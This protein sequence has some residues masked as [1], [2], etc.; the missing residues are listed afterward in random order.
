[1]LSDNQTISDIFFSDPES[2]KFFNLFHIVVVIDSTYKTN[3]YRLHLLE[4]V[5]STYAEQMFYIGFA[6]LLSEKEDNFVWA[7]ERCRE[8][9]K[10]QDHPNTVV[11]DRDGA[12]MNAV[13][14]VFLKF[15]AILCSFTSA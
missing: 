8:L 12:L 4:F 14:R 13:D 6:F 5:G 1:L 9:L 2:I 3:R 11:T 10:C 15:T 7:L